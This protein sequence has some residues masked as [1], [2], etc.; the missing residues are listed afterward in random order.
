MKTLS[1]LLSLVAIAVLSLSGC[2]NDSPLRIVGVF[3]I[4]MMGACMVSDTVFISS[5]QIDLSTTNA[6]SICLGVENG[7]INQGQLVVEGQAID[8]PAT[9]GIVYV[10]EVLHTYTTT[11]A[12]SLPAETLREGFVVRP[13][14]QAA[15]LVA[16]M[17]DAAAQALLDNT[18]AGDTVDVLVTM[19]VRGRVASGGSLTSAP[20][21]WP[22]RVTRK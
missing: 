21:T 9:R 16:L 17:G 6:G 10:E 7:L 22:F 19:R 14:G 18:V 4:D 11:P 3:P 15:A 12:I 2:V 13:E 5:G 20:F 8:D 1:K